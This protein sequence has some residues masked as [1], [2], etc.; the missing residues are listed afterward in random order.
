MENHSYIEFKKERD[1]GS[2]LSDTFRFIRENWKA[3][4]L[5][6]LK[7]SAPAMVVVL[8]ALGFYFYSF[9]GLFTSTTAGDP[10]LSGTLGMGAAAIIL[11]LAGTITY[12]L[13][14][15]SSLFFIKSYIDNNGKSRLL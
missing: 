7:I 3:Y 11:V 15:A 2:I 12:V 14:N 8:A 5:T 10:D 13:M 6:V 4:F 9:S 1:L